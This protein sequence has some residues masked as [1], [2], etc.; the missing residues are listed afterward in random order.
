[1]AEHSEEGNVAGFGWI[2][3]K[4]RRFQVSDPVRFKVPHMGWN[5]VH[6]KK[7]SVLNQDLEKDPS[8][9]FVH[10]Y[11]FS[12]AN[13]ETVLHET[14]YDYPFVSAVEKGHI[15]G[16]QYHPEKSH[17][18]GEQLIRNFLSL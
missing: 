15:F 7:D 11:H 17:E 1:M 8:F 2:S 5:T 9:Y 18:T 10:A 14:V 16:V 12:D 6:F 13:P 4:I 3:G